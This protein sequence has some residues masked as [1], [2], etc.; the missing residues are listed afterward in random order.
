MKFEEVWPYILKGKWVQRAK[1]AMKIRLDP[2]AKCFIDDEESG[3]DLNATSTFN[4]LF[5][6]DDWELVPEPVRVADYLVP[7]ASHPEVYIRRTHPIGQQ[8]D[9]SVLVPGSEREVTNN[10]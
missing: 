10:G 6:C 4:S 9:G 7:D 1:G 5:Y 8:P 3:I 2:D